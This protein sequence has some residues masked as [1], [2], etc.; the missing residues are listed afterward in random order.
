VNYDVPSDTEVYVHRI[1]RT[2]RAGRK[3]DAIIFIS[4]REKRMLHA[5]EKATRSKIEVMDLPST[6][7]IN[8]QRIVRFKKRITDALA[9]EDLGTFPLLVEQYQQEHDVPA[10]EIAAALAHL[11]Q[12]DTPFLLKNKPQP[13]A[14][15]PKHKWEKDKEK[16]ARERE[17][18]PRKEVP[19]DEGLERYRIEVGLKHKVKPGNIVGAIANEADLDSQ[20]IGRIYIHD[21]HSLVDLPEEMPQD[22]FDDLK[23][24]WVS[25]QQLKISRLAQGKKPRKKPSLR[26]DHKGKRRSKAGA[27]PNKIIKKKAAK[28]R[29][30]KS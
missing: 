13:K 25:G 23:E 29:L 7:L 19:P 28:K 22:I 10:L 3:G 9:T 12:G 11:L 14:L 8:D 1:G 30:A 16:P 20:Y 2:G 24:V 6:E 5:I 21:D 26:T 27:R 18:P 4:P 17:R 15:P